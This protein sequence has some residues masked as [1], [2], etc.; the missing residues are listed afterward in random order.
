MSNSPLSSLR[1]PL[2]PYTDDD[3]DELT[4]TNEQMGRLQLY[5][6]GIAVDWRLIGAGNYGIREA[7]ES[8]T[9][10]GEAVDVLPIARR[11]QAMDFS[12]LE[13]IVVSNDPKSETFTDI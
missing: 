13:A 9:P 12:Q 8:I 3:F 5:S 7:D 4:K 1:L 10:L 6:K 2:S 11:P